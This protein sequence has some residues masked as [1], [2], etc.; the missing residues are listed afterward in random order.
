MGRITKDD[1]KV[2]KTQGSGR[3][4]TTIDKFEVW[5]ETKGMRDDVVAEGANETPELREVPLVIDV[6]LARKLD[7]D[8][9]CRRTRLAAT[10]HR[11][12]CLR[13]RVPGRLHPGPGGTLGVVAGLRSTG[14]VTT[15]TAPCGVLSSM[16]TFPSWA[17]TS[18]FTMESPS[19]VPPYSRVEDESTW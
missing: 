8:E 4:V 14:S 18:R 12:F 7:R 9:H 1:K 13:L 19:P 11:C 15:K 6:R 16:R 3:I 2:I 5:F 10:L 17:S